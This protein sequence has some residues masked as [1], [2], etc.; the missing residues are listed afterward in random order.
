MTFCA[1]QIE[2]T[3]FPEG[4]NEKREGEKE[5]SKTASKVFFFFSFCLNKYKKMDLSSTVVG[6][7]L[8]K[9]ACGK[10]DRSGL[11][12]RGYTALTSK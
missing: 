7:L 9:Q 11:W 2:L 4:V 8:M 3:G 12:S 6:K 10:K 5:K 1:L